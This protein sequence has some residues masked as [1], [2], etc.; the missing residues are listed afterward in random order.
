M[1]KEITKEELID[2]ISNT[3]SLKVG[4][5]QGNTYIAGQPITLPLLLIKIDDY[6]EGVIYELD[7]RERMLGF[8]YAI[9]CGEEEKKK[10][11]M[12]RTRP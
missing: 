2:R 6:F 1:A 12:I 8:D 9:P 4:S 5:R 7:N 3:D 11:L 10:S